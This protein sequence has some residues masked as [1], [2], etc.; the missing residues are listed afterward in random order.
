MSNM[1]DKCVLAHILGTHVRKLLEALGRT[2]SAPSVP[3]S[4]LCL[5]CFRYCQ[6]S[7]MLLVEGDLY[8]WGKRVFT[9]WPHFVPVKRGWWRKQVSYSTRTFTKSSWFLCTKLSIYPSKHPLKVTPW[10][11]RFLR[12][13]DS[14]LLFLVL[15]WE[16]SGEPY[17]IC[18]FIHSFHVL[19][20][21]TRC[22]SVR[23]NAPFLLHFLPFPVTF[24]FH[25]FNYL[26]WWQTSKRELSAIPFL[27]ISSLC[28]LLID[29]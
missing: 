11:M 23:S 6:Q 20:I 4:G 19:K 28:L 3:L 15:K 18:D 9:W 24:F 17:H 8:R 22:L 10:L 26:V 1:K 7:C 16:M 29:R 27:Q 2:S 21:L 13:L 12:L 5:L 25:C 14:N